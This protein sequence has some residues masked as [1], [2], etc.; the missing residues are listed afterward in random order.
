MRMSE[1]TEPQLTIGELARCAG[2]TSRAVRHYHATGLLP[3][4]PRDAS[5]YRRYGSG[6][7]TRLLQICRLR[8]LGMPLDQI[9]KALEETADTSTNLPEALLALAVD[10]DAEIDRLK[11][12]HDRLIILAE[13]DD[14]DDDTEEL[15]NAGLRAGRLL[16]LDNL[17]RPSPPLH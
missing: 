1:H 15:L 10:V 6:D 12:V 5:G 13:S 8:A 17:P 11:G 14:L 4:P 2:V 16:D 7:L 9:E 3:E